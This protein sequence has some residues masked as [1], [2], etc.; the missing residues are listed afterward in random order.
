[1][2]ALA[3][4][5]ELTKTAEA[6][7]N[8]AQQIEARLQGLPVDAAFSRSLPSGQ[9]L[10]DSKL[11]DAPIGQTAEESHNSGPALERGAVAVEKRSRHSQ[12]RAPEVK[13]GQEQTTRRSF[14]DLEVMA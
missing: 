11:F 13:M 4:W 7:E 5:P 3:E 8:Q 10:E 6:W 9:Y 2:T 1:G 12:S 14:K